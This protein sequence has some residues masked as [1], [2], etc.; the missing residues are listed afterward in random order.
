[1]AK[2]RGDS[3]AT[4]TTMAVSVA[5]TR[6]RGVF[7]TGKREQSVGVIPPSCRLTVNEPSRQEAFNAANRISGPSGTFGRITAQR[8][9]IMASWRKN[10]ERAE[11]QFTVSHADESDFTHDGLRAFFEYRDLG[12]KEVTAGR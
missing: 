11:M 12:V 8:F 3:K 2:D 4:A 9:K 7:G 1:M 5:A 10:R 6:I